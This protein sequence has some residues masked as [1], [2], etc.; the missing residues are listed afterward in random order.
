MADT[1]TQAYGPAQ[2]GTTIANLYQCPVSTQ[3]VIRNITVTNTTDSPATLFL[4][5]GT[6]GIDTDASRIVDELQVPGAAGT[7]GLVL[8]EPVM[9][10]VEASQYITGKQG[11]ASA[12]TVTISGIEVT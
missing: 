11:T 4:S 8:I 3:F 10:V 12:L 2:P 9:L 6:T 7:H 1:I 5:V